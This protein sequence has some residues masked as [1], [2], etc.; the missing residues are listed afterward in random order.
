MTSLTPFRL[1]QLCKYALQA[2]ASNS[3]LIIRTRR[4]ADSVKQLYLAS[5]RNRKR[6]GHHLVGSH[7]E[8]R[9]GWDTKPHPM[10][11]RPSVLGQ[12]HVDASASVDAQRASSEYP[13][14]GS[15]SSLDATR[16]HP[17]TS[18]RDLAR[19]LSSH[20][21]RHH[22]QYPNEITRL[23]ADPTLFKPSF[24]APR[25]VIVL[26][27]GLYG[28]STATP[29]PLFPSL[30]LHYWA[31][32][33]EVLREKLG[34]KVM[35]VG[36][37]GTGSIQERALEMD[38]WLKEKLPKGTGVNFVAHSMGGL[39]CRY[40]ITHLKP[41][42]YTPLSLTMIGTPNRGSPFMDWCAVSFLFARLLV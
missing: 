7:V 19:T 1:F 12:Q 21:G 38:A 20:G 31:S 30:K 8:E 26:C 29:I 40:L 14:A 33:L 13:L 42:T 11:G 4:K 6:H 36:V 37:K 2:Y 3:P 5:K 17:S 15:S 9:R 10:Q 39:D 35:V 23:M 27:H 16:R 18:D 34:C 24:Q 32:V 22:R 25:N 41:E 28:F